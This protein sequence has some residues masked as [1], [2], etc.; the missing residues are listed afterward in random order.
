M[1]I[2]LIFTSTINNRWGTVV[3]PKEREALYKESIEKTL[4]F[5]GDRATPII[6][7]N[8]VTTGESYLDTCGPPVLY[9][10]NNYIDVPFKATLEFLDVQSVIKHYE[11]ADDDVVIKITGRYSLIASAYIDYVISTLDKFDVWMKFYNVCTFKYEAYDCVM[12]CYAIRA[13][14]LK[15]IDAYKAINEVSFASYIRGQPGIRIGDIK[16]IGLKCTFAD[17]LRSI[18]V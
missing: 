14:Y 9:T 17:D 10:K 15:N 6:V 18:C 16:N 2:W 7:E 13:K 11:I 4:K 5:V 1:K 12:G 3:D 8:S